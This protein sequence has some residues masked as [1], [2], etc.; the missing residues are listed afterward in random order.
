MKRPRAGEVTLHDCLWLILLAL[1]ALTVSLLAAERWGWAGAL[2]GLIVGFAGI[3]GALYLILTIWV[4]AE[5]G[6]FPCCHRGICCGNWR[7]PLGDYD[8]VRFGDDHGYR[9]KCG[10]EYMKKGRR[11][12]LRRPDGTLEPYMVWKP[13]RGFVPDDENGTP[14]TQPPP[15]SK[16]PS[17]PA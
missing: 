7:D 12:M 15:R 5:R 6:W 10:F 11:F 8:I 3:F 16:P 14:A 2:L 9:C 1:G 4:I 13:L 17:G